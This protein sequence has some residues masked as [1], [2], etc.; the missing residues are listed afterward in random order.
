MVGR[1]VRQPVEHIAKWHPRS[2]GGVTKRCA[3]PV[4]SQCR[5]VCRERERERE[6]LLCRWDIQVIRLRVESP[7]PPACPSKNTGVK[8]NRFGGN[9]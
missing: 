1:L 4:R 8:R 9:G 6:V 2:H 5:L 7:Q 3:A